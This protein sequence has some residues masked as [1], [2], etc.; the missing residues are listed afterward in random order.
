MRTLLIPPWCI[1]AEQCIHRAKDISASHAIRPERGWGWSW[2]W[3]HTVLGLL[4]RAA[5]RDVPYDMASCW[6][7]KLV[8][9]AEGSIAQR[10]GRH[11]SAGVEELHHFSFIPIMPFLFWPIKLSISTHSFYFFSP[12]SFLCPPGLGQEGVSKQLRCAELP[13]ELN[14]DI[15]Q[16]TVRKGKHWDGDWLA[17][18]K[19]KS[20]SHWCRWKYRQEERL[21]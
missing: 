14:H 18:S 15:V 6:T 17:S 1:V 4:T 3:Q 12:A 10:L 21:F 9:L 5:Q 19:W 13:A 20:T 7:V 8:E 16:T 2:R 11:W